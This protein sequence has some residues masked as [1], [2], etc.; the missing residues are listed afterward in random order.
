MCREKCLSKS[1][2]LVPPNHK[3]NS[4]HFL[5]GVTIERGEIPWSQALHLTL[6]SGIGNLDA[7]H[8]IGKLESPRALGHDR[9]ANQRPSE[10]RGFAL[11]HAPQRVRHNLFQSRGCVLQ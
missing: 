2:R 9:P 7:Q 10:Q 5:A 4:L 3:L 1:T 8:A 11:R 6:P